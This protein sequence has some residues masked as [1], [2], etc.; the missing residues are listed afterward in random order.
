MPIG[1]P[2]WPELACWTA[3]IARARMA[4]AMREAAFGVTGAEEGLRDVV[5]ISGNP[6]RNRGRWRRGAGGTSARHGKAPDFTRWVW[7][8]FAV[9][10]IRGVCFLGTAPPA[11]VGQR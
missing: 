1:A 10:G 2:G 9:C 11:G 6:E 4:L 5:V 8:C 7:R 3:S